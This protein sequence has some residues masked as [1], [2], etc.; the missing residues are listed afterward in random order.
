MML[1]VKVLSAHLRL[2][3][4]EQHTEEYHFLERHHIE[5]SA[6]SRTGKV[7]YIL[8]MFTM[9]QVFYAYATRAVLSVV[10]IQIS[11]ENELLTDNTRNIQWNSLT[12]GFVLGSFYVGYAVSQIPGSLA[13]YKYG[14]KKLIGLGTFCIALCNIITPITTVTFGANGI[15]IL[16][17]LQGIAD[18]LTFP[19][20]M[21]FLS[22]WSPENERSFLTSISMTG[23]YTGTLIAMSVSAYIIKWSG[24][25]TVYYIYG[26]FGVLWYI[27][28]VFVSS[29]SPEDHPFI[30]EKE[31]AY[32][33]QT[34]NMNLSTNV[35]KIP[36]KSMFRSL[37][38]YAISI[39]LF[40]QDWGACLLMAIQPT[41][42]YKGLE[43][44]LS[45]S[46][47]YS[48]IP[49]IVQPVIMA[50]G[51]K[52]ADLVYERRYTSVFSGFTYVGLLPNMI[53]INPEY[54]GIIMAVANTFASFSGILSVFIAG[55]IISNGSIEEWNIVFY[56]TGSFYIIGIFAFGTLSSAIKDCKHPS[57]TRIFTGPCPSGKIM[58]TVDAYVENCGRKILTA[59]CLE[60][61]INLKGNTPNFS[62]IQALYVPL[63]FQKLLLASSKKLKSNLS[64]LLVHP[65]QF[66]ESSTC[67]SDSFISMDIKKLQESVTQSIYRP[68]AVKNLERFIVFH[69][70]F[71]FFVKD[72]FIFISFMFFVQ[73]LFFLKGS[74][75]LPS[76]SVFLFNGDVTYHLNHS[77][78]LRSSGSFLFLKSIVCFSSILFFF[79]RF[80][81]SMIYEFSIIIIYL[82]YLLL[83]LGIGGSLNPT[84]KKIYFVDYLTESQW[85]HNTFKHPYL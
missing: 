82:H 34:R 72:W 66:L 64:L 4:I 62:S 12:Q 38:F 49:Y 36:W 8:A 29:E 2:K 85:E 3:K 30:T 53:D 68:L 47:I 6:P 19:C 17:I 56:V 83:S 59:K 5:L 35:L 42:L 63:N 60:L 74:F 18:G 69:Y 54:S 33:I 26:S 73:H 61:D 84:K 24:W 23:I 27:L 31:R 46:S 80:F 37:P 16:R 44:S 77:S 81:R 20:L 32:I 57:L 10:I 52:F 15:I 67:C 22:K 1:W 70:S 48:G 50:I 78:Q 75:N 14:S 51:G 65:F 39:G 13:A 28:W 79:F 76:S 11:L 41:Y 45:K 9:F 21:C 43:Y 71:Y 58:S 7:R 55:K 40:C 25:N